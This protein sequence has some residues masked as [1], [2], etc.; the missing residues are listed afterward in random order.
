MALD[1][2]MVETDQGDAIGRIS[3]VDYHGDV[4]YDKFVK[5]EKN[6]TDYRTAVSGIRQ[7]DLKD[8]IT[9]SQSRKEV[10]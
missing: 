6:I 9:F 2:E 10:I 4:L 3:I 7:E 5:P 1:C 8:A